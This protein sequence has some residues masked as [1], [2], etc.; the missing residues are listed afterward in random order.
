M[1]EIPEATE[2]KA[3]D[4]EAASGALTAACAAAGLDAAGAELIRIGENAVFRL[5][6]PVIAR[7]ARTASYAEAA[8]RE[9]AVARWL[10][11]CGYPATRALGIEQ[12]VVVDGRVVTFWESVSDEEEFAPLE[13]VARLIRWLHELEEP[14]L[15]LPELDPF[16]R[17]EY[18]LRLAHAGLNAA[19]FAY[20]EQRVNS[21]RRQWGEL[22]FALSRG[23]VHGDASIGNVIRSSTGEPVLIDLDGFA[24]GPREWDL[25]QTAMYYER[26]GWHTEQEYRTFVEVYGYDLLTWPDYPKL[27]DIRETLMTLWL[28]QKAQHDQRSADEV[29][30]RLNT[31]RTG[32]DRRDWAPY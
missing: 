12:P 25:V 3:L 29:H 27:A 17:A 26:F 5:R 31:L 24:T 30:K 28:S 21:A 8:R 18:R 20:L 6:E 13:E 4:A 14:P 22:D 11:D 2:A 15:E 19:D 1:A 23:A 9:V 16:A 32:A 7:I 10:E